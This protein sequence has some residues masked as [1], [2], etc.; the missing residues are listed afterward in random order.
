MDYEVRSG[1][2]VIQSIFDHR[3]FLFQSV[4]KTVQT[5][6]YAVE[7][8]HLDRFAPASSE[9]ELERMALTQSNNQSFQ[10][11][12]VFLGQAEDEDALYTEA[13]ETP[14][15][16]KY[17]IRMS[18][19]SV[20]T[21]NQIKDTLWVPGPDDNYFLDLKYLRGFIQ[22]QDLVDRAILSVTSQFTNSTD[23]SNVGVYTQ[24]FP[25]PCFER[26]K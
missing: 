9:E 22:L 20:P 5:V 7:C 4:W 21:T 15:H 6:R 11:G 8:Y 13:D 26:D 17:K 3:H 18:R 23:L 19:S 10:A 24:Q 12:I 25:Y 16:V 2:E 14:K 1:F